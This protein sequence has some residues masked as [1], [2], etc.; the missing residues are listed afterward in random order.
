MVDAAARGSG[1]AL[2]G[3]RVLVT[4]PRH[5]SAGLVALIEKCGGTA[6]RFPVIEILPVHEPRT[7][8]LILASLDDFDWVIFVSPNAVEHGLALM[9]IQRARQTRARLA[10]VGASTAAALEQ[11]GFACVLRPAASASSEALL[12]L[13]ELQGDAVAGSRILIV[14]GEG[15][16]PLLGDT[17][18]KRGARVQYAEVYRRGRPALDDD[19]LAKCGIDGG[20][21]GGIDT[22]VITSLQGLE[23]LFALLGDG[24]HGWLRQAG[25]VVVSERLAAHVHALGIVHQSVIAAGAGDEALIEA[26]IRWRATY[27]GN[28][29]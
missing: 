2:A 10:A 26:L 29:K 28:G 19:G 20:S 8:R 27:P 21:D 18:S 4:R 1:G 24:A 5:Q 7:A 13:P 23:N 25:Y 9:D 15:G 17:L 22:I 11:A 12:A 16:R 6:I 3:L 14:R